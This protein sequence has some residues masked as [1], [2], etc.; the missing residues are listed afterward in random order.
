MYD[1]FAQQYEFARGD[2]SNKGGQIQVEDFAR[3]LARKNEPKSSLVM[4]VSVVMI[5]PLMVGCPEP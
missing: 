1:M 5:W 4:Q 3:A 2:E